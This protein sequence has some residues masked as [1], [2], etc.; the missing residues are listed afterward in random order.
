MHKNHTESSSRHNKS[1]NTLWVIKIFYQFLMKKMKMSLLPESNKEVDFQGALH[2]LFPVYHLAQAE[3]NIPLQL[4]LSISS[5]TFYL[6]FCVE[7][8]L[9]FLFLRQHFPAFSGNNFMPD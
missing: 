8:I 7:A 6:V 4:I 3:A 5:R 1:T 9:A 2:S